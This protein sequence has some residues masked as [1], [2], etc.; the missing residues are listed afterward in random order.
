MPRA[1]RYANGLLRGLPHAVVTVDH[2]HAVKLANEAI[3]DVRRRVQN[4][5]LGPVADIETTPS[6]APG[7]S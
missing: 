5:T 6:T 7:A 1:S 4:E 2:F 3:N